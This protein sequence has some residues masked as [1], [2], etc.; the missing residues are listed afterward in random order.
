MVRASRGLRNHWICLLKLMASP[1]D[2]LPSYDEYGDE[3]GSGIGGA[4]RHP[5]Q[6][7]CGITTGVI[8]AEV[9]TLRR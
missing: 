9:E 5:E 2:F 8:N 6:G 3:L 1:N 4:M 7:V